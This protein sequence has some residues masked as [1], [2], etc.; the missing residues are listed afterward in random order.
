MGHYL[1]N[2]KN[3]TYQIV[4]FYLWYFKSLTYF[5]VMVFSRFLSLINDL[6]M[7]SEESY[8]IQISH[9]I[10]DNINEWKANSEPTRRKCV[11]L[12]IEL[13]SIIY[14][15]IIF[16]FSYPMILSGISILSFSSNAKWIEVWSWQMK[17]VV[18]HPLFCT[19]STPSTPNKSTMSEIRLTMVSAA[20]VV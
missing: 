4:S 7:R 8:R 1:N 19:K 18:P 13:M 9:S 16:L 20:W 11:P 12:I 15:F 10:F 3:K 2:L 5:I 6:R 17:L 14:F